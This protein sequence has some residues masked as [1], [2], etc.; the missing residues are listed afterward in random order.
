[1][2][3]LFTRQLLA[4]FIISSMLLQCVASAA[5]FHLHTQGDATH[6][7]VHQ[8]S[9]THIIE[10]AYYNSI[11]KLCTVISSPNIAAD[12]YDHHCCHSVSTSVALAVIATPLL[13]KQRTSTALYSVDFYT[14]PVSDS[15]IRPP[16]T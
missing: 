2:Q 8:A 5:D 7:H 6:S 14:S 13:P 15:L 16:I 1:M 11:N 12:L 4:C 10:T 9:E 3:S